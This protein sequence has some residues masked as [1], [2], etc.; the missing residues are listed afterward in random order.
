MMIAKLHVNLSEAAAEVV[1]LFQ[2][3]RYE[4]TRTELRDELSRAVELGGSTIV[5]WHMSVGVVDR[6]IDF[7]VGEVLGYAARAA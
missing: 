7:V 4:L 3:A 5:P 1:N 6:M 2:I